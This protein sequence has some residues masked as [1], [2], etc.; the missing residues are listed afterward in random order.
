MSLPLIYFFL[1]RENL[2]A[3]GLLTLLGISTDIFDGI[4]ARKLKQ[5]SNLGKILDPLVDKIGLGVFAIYAVLYKDFPLWAAL[6]VISRDL[7]ILAG[8]IFM[9]KKNKEV[10]VSDMWGKLTA[11][12][13]ALCILAYILD[14]DLIRKVLL[15]A[16]LVLTFFSLGS[17]LRKFMSNQTGK[18]INF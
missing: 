1:V 3:V 18:R 5:A 14:I 12:A 13:W 8:G 15:V 17:Y 2:M 16:G 11:L 9:L 4:L 6:L 7:A 10:P